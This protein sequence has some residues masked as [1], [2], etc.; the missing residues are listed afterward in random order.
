MKPLIKRVLMILALGLASAA[1]APP[2][3]ALAKSCGGSGQAA[4]AWHK[5]GPECRT[6]LREVRG[7]CKPCGAKGQKACKII[8]KGKACKPGLLIKKG[9]CVPASSTM[10]GQI[11]DKVGD[12]VGGVFGGG[13]KEKLQAASRKHGPEIAGIARQISLALPDGRDAKALAQAIKDKDGRAI[14]RI[15]S[16]NSDLRTSFEALERMGFKTVT[17]GIETSGSFV[18]GGAHET[19]FAMD[20]DFD[21]TPK[22]YTTTSLSGGYHFGGGNDLVFSFFRSS[23]TKIDGHAFG[24]IAEFDAG[25]GVGLNMWFTSKPFDFAGFSIGI[26]IGSLGGGGAVTYALT[27]IWN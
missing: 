11:G 7:Y 21:G 12:T 10:I 19:G 24:T 26:G 2:S 5:P 8:S 4:C 25:S 13:K 3:A 27:K 18:A 16:N 17:V 23:H 9:K 1:M 20:L 22:L 15:L 14:Q 6:W